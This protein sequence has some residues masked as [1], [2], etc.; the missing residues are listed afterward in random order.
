MLRRMSFIVSVGQT[1]YEASEL[2]WIAVTHA[3]DG[4]QRWGT[5]RGGTD[6]LI[7]IIDARGN[8]LMETDPSWKIRFLYLQCGSIS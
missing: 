4:S 5:T 8:E 6:Y 3:L 7:N 1:D 2:G